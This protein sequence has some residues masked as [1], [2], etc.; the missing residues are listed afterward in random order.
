MLIKNLKAN[1][2]KL[3]LLLTIASTTV[4]M[5]IIINSFLQPGYR[6][7]ENGRVP[8]VQAEELETADGKLN[9]RYGVTPLQ[10]DQVPW[11]DTLGAGWFLNFGPTPPGSMP[12]NG[13]EFVP[14]IHVTQKK[15]GSIYLDDYLVGGFSGVDAENYV[16]NLVNGNLGAL[17]LVGNEPDVPIVQGDIYP[18]VYARAYHDVYQWI[19]QTDPTAQVA[20]GG[21]SMMTPARLQYLDIVWDTYA[22]LYNTTLPVD[23]WNM[24]L[25][26]LS[27]Y[28]SS[29]NPPY[30]DGKLALG[31][32]PAIAK[33]ASQGKVSLCPL[34]DVYC[35]AEHDSMTI[36]QSQ[37]NG[38][39]TWMKEHGEQDKPLI[40]SEYSLLYP[41]VDY[42][43]LVNPTVC[44]LMDENGNCFTPA[45]VKT[46][47]NA[48]F[49]FLES[50]NTS[51][52]N[53][54][55]NYRLV[56]QWMWFGLA[57]DTESTGGSSNLLLVTEVD[58]AEDV[59]T[60]QSYTPGHVNALNSVGLNFYNHVNATTTYVN[61]MAGKAHPAIGEIVA[62]STTATVTLSVDF[63]NN[64]NTSLSS[65]FQVTF[66]EDAALTTPIG[67]VAI[68]PTLLGCA[69]QT[70]TASVTW[71][72]LT[73]GAHSYWVKIDS[74][75]SVAESS[76]GE[77]DN[78]SQ[79][80]VLID[81][82]T[83]FLPSLMR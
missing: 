76:P 30:G 72:G 79:G 42:D 68:N 14:V 6:Q 78:V 35:R 47:M 16:K 48:S 65:P 70:Y 8:V 1:T 52:G 82:Q 27:E 24:H 54:N 67:S 62:P 64:G 9:C 13:A 36:F 29:N 39:R 11:V 7:G 34:D 83:V 2:K 66:Y 33:L 60:Y 22:A 32:D 28:D 69:R 81:P 45:R 58:N 43:D 41:F 4:A 15:S 73:A 20:V 75:N 61:L 51:I 3:Y 80:I 77:T 50:S 10:N 21:L 19:K 23:V 59:W 49:N 63:Y 12:G 74:S 5:I 46:F 71:P 31:T 18:N 26:I 38:M 17:W 25:Y 57:T 44:F 55:D 40:L 53:P 56:Q 37:I